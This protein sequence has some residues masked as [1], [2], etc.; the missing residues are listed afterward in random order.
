MSE[1]KLSPEFRGYTHVH[2]NCGAFCILKHD[3]RYALLLN[4]GHVH[5]G[6]Q[7]AFTPIG[8]GIKVNQDTRRELERHLALPRDS[9][10]A[11]FRLGKKSPVMRTVGGALPGNRD[12]RF[13]MP[14]NKLD[15]FIVWLQERHE[16]RELSPLREMM[17]ELTEESPLLNPADVNQINYGLAGYSAFWKGLKNNI[18]VPELKIM[19]LYQLD[20]PE[21]V[22]TRLLQSSSDPSS[23]LRFATRDEIEAGMTYDHRRIGNSARMLFD[24]KPTIEIPE[25]R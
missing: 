20:P 24:P 12:L 7:P 13:S 3:D 4:S 23:P 15:T 25:M 14:L 10:D 5:E 6:I 1:T 11:P 19:E 9:F 8:G 2:M 22:M 17:E 16:G 21:E 18:Q